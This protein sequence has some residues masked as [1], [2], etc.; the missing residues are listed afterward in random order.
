MQNKL[1][2]IAILL[3]S[4]TG[5]FG[6]N[7]QNLTVKFNNTALQEAIVKVETL[8]GKTFFFDE[9]WLKG[10]FVTKDF[11]NESLRKVLDELFSNTNIN[12]FL[13]MSPRPERKSESS[14]MSVAKY[15]HIY[16]YS[17]SIILRGISSKG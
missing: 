8:S 13:K 9:T 15:R 10:H 6:Q 2:V 11:E 16:S 14:S 4:T 1:L 3:L 12:Y 5:I 17:E 7:N